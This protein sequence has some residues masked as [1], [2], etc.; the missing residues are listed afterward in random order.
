MSNPDRVNPG[1]SLIGR[2]IGRLR[3]RPDSEHE[4]AMIRI[5]IVGLLFTYLWA[6]GAL[7][8]THLDVRISAFLAGGYLF[9]SCLYLALSSFGRARRPLRRLTAMV[10]DFGMIS[11]FM[12]FGGAEAAPFYP[13]YLWV[14]FGNGFRYGLVYLAA[15][16]SAAVA[17]FLIVV[18]T[19]AFWRDQLPLSLGLLAAIAIL[20]SYAASLIR[21]LTEAK[22]QAEAAN[23]AK[24]KFLASMSHELRTPLNAVIGMSD[25]LRDTRL[26]SDQ[27]EMVHIVKNIGR[28]AI[29]A[30]RRY[31]RPVPHRGEQGGGLA[32]RFRS[33]CLP[34]RP[35][36]DV[37]TA[38]AASWPHLGRARRGRRAVAVARGC[39]ASSPNFDQPHRQRAQVHLSWQGRPGCSS[40]GNGTPR[41]GQATLPCERHRRRYLPRSIITGS[42]S[43]SLK[44]TIR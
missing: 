39:S 23:Q 22:A 41:P 4:Q 38:G 44:P 27:R 20:P 11:A 21:K 14:A 33:L 1:L 37:S 24:S 31:S 13:I 17:G 12:H 10:T 42:S 6:A 16:V 8:D 40:A 28:G 19:T 30:D 35:D 43:D 9:V 34:R 5:I 26:D 32:Y 7:T 2:V 25:L 29:V 18:L 15:S 36:R 3:G